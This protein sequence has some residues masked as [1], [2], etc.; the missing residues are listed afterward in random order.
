VGRVRIGVRVEGAGVGGEFIILLLVLL[1]LG[2]VGVISVF[3]LAKLFCWLM[4]FSL[5]FVRLK[6]V[7]LFWFSSLERSG[8]VETKEEEK[9]LFFKTPLLLLLLLLF[10]STQ[11]SSLLKVWLVCLLV[12]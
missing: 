4:L 5:L 11:S 9:L 12:I 2:L 6:L 8:R 3:L 7:S 1:V 10:T